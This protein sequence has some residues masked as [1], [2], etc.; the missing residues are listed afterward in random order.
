M[1]IRVSRIGAFFLAVVLALSFVALSGCSKNKTAAASSLPYPFG[2]EKL[3]ELKIPADDWAFIAQE[4]GWLKESFEQHGVKV[5]LVQGSLGNEIQLFSIKDL[6]FAN[7]MLYPYLLYRTQ[8]ADII[9]VE[10]SKHPEPEIAS[11]M[12][13]ADSPYKTFDDLKGKKIAS[14]RAGCPY[15]VLFELAEQRNWVQGKDWTYVNIP[16][17]NNK[18]ALLSKE[19]D[20]VSGHI[21]ANDLAPLLVGG[22]TREVAY[23]EED[24]VYINGGGVT[25]LF[26]PVEFARNYPKITREYISIRR[27]TEKWMLTNLD[28]GAA[29]VEGITRVPAEVSKLN[30]QRMGST[31]ETTKLGL[32]TIQEQTKSMQDWLVEHGDI[33]AD[34][35]VDPALLFDPQYFQV[36]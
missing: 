16:T 13:L 35:Q 1:K 31:W 10:V 29:I 25:V 5:S 33:A 2:D 36:N 27:K 18:N 30:W 20:A 26:T 7:R 8:G 3:A 21:I 12:V 28:E 14:W 34:K 17:G 11:I 15:M 24:S 32:A 9:A 23:P 19:I 4:K 6:H 22:I